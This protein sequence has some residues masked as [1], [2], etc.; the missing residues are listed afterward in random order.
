MAIRDEMHTL[1]DTLSDEQIAAA[2]A[3]LRDLAAAQPLSAR[4]GLARRMDAGALTGAAFLAAQP[5]DLAT[6]AAQQDVQPV[7]H[8]HDIESALWPSG[9][10]ED[11]DLFAATLR[12]WR[13]SE[14]DA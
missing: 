1:V 4:G 3:Y 13:R 5:L 9:P 6:L 10:E 7:A 2:H 14:T 11:P 12:H 8:A